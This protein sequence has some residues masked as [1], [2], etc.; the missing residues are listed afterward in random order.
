MDT[1][2]LLMTHLKF[3]FGE[4]AFLPFSKAALAFPRPRKRSWETVRQP[5]SLVREKHGGALP[6]QLAS[7]PLH[8]SPEVRMPNQEQVNELRRVTASKDHKRETGFP[9]W[10]ISK[11]RTSKRTVIWHRKL[12]VKRNKAIY[13]PIGSVLFHRA[14][15][16]GGEGMFS[17]IFS[18]KKLRG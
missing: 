10:N 8:S 18:R 9:L 4:K 14:I 5:Q 11:Y 16:Q 2:Q 3:H 1:G 15:W 12:Y 17:N 6:S 13:C 7:F